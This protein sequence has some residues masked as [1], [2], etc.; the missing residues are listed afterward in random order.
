MFSVTWKGELFVAKY[1][2][3]F[4][5]IQKNASTLHIEILIHKINNYPD[6]LGRWDLV[7]AVYAMVI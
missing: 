6:R 5:P 4:I 2:N 7:I 1:E 3:F